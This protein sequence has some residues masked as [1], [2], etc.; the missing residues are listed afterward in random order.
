VAPQK[1]GPSSGSL[2]GSDPM[3]LPYSFGWLPASYVSLEAG[4]VNS[5]VKGGMVSSDLEVMLRGTTTTIIGFNAL[6]P[7]ETPQS[8]IVTTVNG[9]TVSAP[10]IPTQPINGGKAFFESKSAAA[11]EF[12]PG[13][14]SSGA[15][16]FT[17]LSWQLPNGRWAD[18]WP[19]GSP[20]HPGPTEAELRRIAANMRFGPSPAPLPIHISALPQ[21]FQ[22]RELTMG[23]RVNGSQEWT[24][25]AT[26]ATPS[27]TK[28]DLWI[29]PVGAPDA[30]GIGSNGA[31]V[32]SNGL[33]MTAY[34]NDS[35]TNTSSLDSVGGLK[36]LLGH[37]TSLG[38]DT[39]NWTTKVLG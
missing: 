17:T 20:V 8:V 12:N 37:V 10:E 3:I 5:S 23:S 35:G 33:Q 2:T 9:K 1:G 22:L 13:E 15:P 36:G 19:T 29:T 11:T 30:G 26:Y 18:L 4:D 34:M 31:T 21:G 7:G 28:V 27:G 24:L 38:T 16:S 32:V 25:M 6:G 14:P 39:D